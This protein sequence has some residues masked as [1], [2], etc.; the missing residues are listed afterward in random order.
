MT[1]GAAEVI[2]LIAGGGQFPFLVARAGRAAGARVVAVG[3]AG[4]TDPALAAETASYVELHLGQVSRLLRTFKDQ[5]ATRVVF[6]GTIN[7][8]RAMDL[9][10][11]WLAAKLL[12]R[13]AGKGDDAILST[14]AGELERQGLLL[15]SALDLLPGMATPV[16]P[17]TA[18]PPRDSD[19]DDLRL[20][21]PM[22]K[23]LGRMDIGQ[24]LL[25]RSGVV[26]AVEGPEGTDAA[27]ARAGSLLGKGCVLCKIFKPG[28]DARIDLPAAGPG[29][30]R[31]MAA[32]GGACIG[33]E[34]GRSVF[35][36]LEESVALAEAGG[37][38]LVGLTAEYLGLPPEAGA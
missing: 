35:F 28:Q 4:N 9:R 30:V 21:W 10:P 5:G 1:A 34:A 14:L 23:T 19:L 15:S 12:L 3:F 17:L 7:K 25:I 11:D 33:I 22:A 37:I 13:L 31:A 29:T 6:A 32:V 2:G 38:R 16:G 26:G 20:A 8:P 36:D 24:S 27:I 18:K